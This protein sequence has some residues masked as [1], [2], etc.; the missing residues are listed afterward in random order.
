MYD[1]DFQIY[2][3]EK[4][5]VEFA[6][7]KNLF[8]ENKVNVFEVA[9][10][11][12]ED[13]QIEEN[14]LGK[15]W[16]SYLGYAYVDPSSSIVN[17]EYI[18]KVGDE[19]ILKNNALP[20]YKFGKAVTVT[21]SYPTNPFIQDKMEKKLNELVSFVFCFPFDIEIYV[22]RNKLKKNQEN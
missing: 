16:G 4:T 6:I 8:E 10:K 17:Q 12:I 20:L 13:Y 7:I 21:T 11:L 22:Q 14:E 9:L 3:S 5:G 2:L 18:N 15:I 1:F 19:F